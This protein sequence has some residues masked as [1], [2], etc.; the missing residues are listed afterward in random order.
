MLL[1]R[2]LQLELVLCVRQRLPAEIFWSTSPH[3][4]ARYHVHLA[5]RKTPL[6]RLVWHAQCKRRRIAGTEPPRR[7]G[8]GFK[9]FPGF[10]FR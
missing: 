3:T 10:F 9:L 5:P 2:R 1:Q 7:C 8:H 6:A 4:H